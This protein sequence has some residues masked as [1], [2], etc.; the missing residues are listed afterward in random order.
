MIIVSPF[1]YWAV[2]VYQACFEPQNTET[3]GTPRRLATMEFAS[4]TDGQPS[5]RT[6]PGAKNPILFNPSFDLGNHGVPDA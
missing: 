6:V 1:S 5:S 2:R 4:L 3:F